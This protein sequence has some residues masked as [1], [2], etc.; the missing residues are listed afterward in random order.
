EQV[1]TLN[2]AND[3]PTWNVD[4]WQARVYRDMGNVPAAL[5][6]AQQ[7]L[8]SA[9]ADVADDIQAFVDEIEQLQE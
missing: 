1:R 7:A 3:L 2:E 8:L 5:A 6:L 4:Y 9:P